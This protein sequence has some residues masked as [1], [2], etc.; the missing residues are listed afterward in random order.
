ML[1]WQNIADDESQMYLLKNMSSKLGSPTLIKER[2]IDNNVY[3]LEEGRTKDKAPCLY[4]HA[5]VV[6]GIVIIMS[7]AFP[8]G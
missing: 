2:L 6:N 8:P 1:I 3:F 7:L 5:K 4:F